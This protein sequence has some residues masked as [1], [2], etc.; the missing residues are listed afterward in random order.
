M[1]IKSYD[2]WGMFVC[3]LWI[4]FLSLSPIVSRDALIHHMALPK[5]WLERGIF[6]IDKYR[7]YAFY[8]SNLQALY[9]AA[10][11][12]HLEFLPKIIHSLFLFATGCLVYQYLRFA[13]INNHL[14]SLA[15]CLTLTIPICQRLASQAYVDLGLLFFSTLSLVYFLYW[16]NSHFCIKKYFY[17]SALAAGLAL[18]TKYN[19][20]LLPAILFLLCLLV[21]GKYTKKYTTSLLYGCEFVAIAIVLASPWLIRNYLASG[22]NPFFPLFTSIFPD[23]IKE[24]KPLYPVL[25][26]MIFYR[27]IEGESLIE[28]LLLPLRIF[29][30]GEDDNFLRFDGKLNPMMLVLIPFA[31]MNRKGLRSDSAA[32]SADP[33][34]PVVSLVSDRLILLLFVVAVMI[35]SLSSHDIRI[36]YLIPIISPII[37]LNIFSIDYLLSQKKVLLNYLSYLSIFI[38][39]LY[40]IFYGYDILYRVDHVKFLLGKESQTDYIRRKVKFYPI[41][42]YINHHTEHN[43]VIYDVMS[44]QR[45]YYVNREYIHHPRHVDTI[46]MNYIIQKKRYSD[47]EAYL[48]NLET[49]YGKGVTHLLI[50]PYLFINAYKAIYPTYDQSAIRNFIQFLNRQKLLFQSGDIRLYRLIAQQAKQTVTQGSLTGAGG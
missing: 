10:L 2:Y 42:E 13:G 1:R 20:I 33:T 31:F 18:G 4:L 29:F 40:N 34:K 26:H 22:G 23:T 45:S 9:Q 46:F 44:G 11:F 36:R 43:A 12:Y 16:K 37:I 21:Y 14:A 47:Y 25:K 17:I 41:Y 7:I 27:M 15:F 28:I 35:I 3:L 24:A 48:D 6:S 32:A 38:Y 30:A 5:L 19:G 8:P 50:R 39:I 49:Q